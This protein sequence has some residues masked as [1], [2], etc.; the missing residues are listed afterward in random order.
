MCIFATQNIEDMK[1]NIKKLVDTAVKGIQEKKGRSINIVDMEG[2]E[3]VITQ[4]FVICEGGS[5]TQVSAIMDSVEETMR[6]D[7]KEKPVRIAGAD[8]CIWVAM[9]YVDLMVHIFLPEARDFYN[10]EELWQDA[11]MTE[12]PDL[13]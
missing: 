5:P 13:D 10:L 4:S 9:D 1:E 6:K 3:G 2:M 7:L 12:V 11:P 8:N